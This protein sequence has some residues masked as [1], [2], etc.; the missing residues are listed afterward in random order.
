MKGAKR[1]DLKCFHH[2]KEMV[3]T[4]H[5]HG[6]GLANATVE[7]ILQIKYQINTLNTLHLHNDKYQLYLNKAEGGEAPPPTCLLT[8]AVFPRPK[9][10]ATVDSVPSPS[11]VKTGP[12]LPWCL[13]TCHSLTSI[14]H[15]SQRSVPFQSG[16]T[17][18]LQELV[19][20]L[21]LIL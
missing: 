17:F 13:H 15:S 16:S 12:G 19:I 10:G 3:M 14:L 21:H 7:I 5:G 11:L 6:G 1:V 9:P 8:I 20:S 18:L 2:Q 4:R